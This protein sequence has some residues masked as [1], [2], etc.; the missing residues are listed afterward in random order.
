[1]RSR[2]YF[3]PES[4][5]LHFPLVW[6]VKR[7][8]HVGFYTHNRTT[9]VI[10]T[11][12]IEGHNQ[13]QISHTFPPLSTRVARAASVAGKSLKCR[14]SKSVFRLP[15]LSFSTAARSAMSA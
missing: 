11:V 10:S 8:A 13:Y 6:I 14:T 1:F 7:I 2:R 3:C 9:A 4:Y 5:V 12:T 15:S